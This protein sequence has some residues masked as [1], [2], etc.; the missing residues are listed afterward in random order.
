MMGQTNTSR[1]AQRGSALLVSLVILLVMTLLGVQSMNSTL[2]EEKMSGNY[3]DNQLAFE[4]AEA[5]LR[6]GERALKGFL[7]PPE[8]TNNGANDVWTYGSVVGADYVD[9]SWWTANGKTVTQIGSK[10]LAY[11]AMYIIQEQQRVRD[12]GKLAVG[13]NA[14]PE[15]RYFYRVV[16]RGV[17]A[18]GNAEVL[19]QSTFIRL[20]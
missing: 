14:E 17:G 3:R 2:M 12:S 13:S 19:L 4:A 6:E 11:P 15:R 16:A 18:S 9:T 7:G 20:F 8:A 5:A 1:F 10:T